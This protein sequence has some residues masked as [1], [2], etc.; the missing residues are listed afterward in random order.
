MNLIIDI[1]N[2]YSKLA[3]FQEERIL[4]K[5]QVTGS[6]I[7]SAIFEVL[8]K[9]KEIDSVIVSNV[10]GNDVRFIE[11]LPEQLNI[12]E[13]NSQ[14]KLP[15][16][17]LYVTPTT[18]GND[19]KALMAAAARQFYTQHVLVIDAGTCITY[20][21]KNNLNEYLGGAISPGLEMRYRALNHFTGRLPLE[22]KA[23]EVDLIGNTT[24][25]S[26]NSGVQN[27]ILNEV[28]GFIDAYEAK[29]ENLVVIITGGDAQF[30]SIN[31]K[32]TIFANSNFLLEGLNYILEF[33]NSQ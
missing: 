8:S 18:L 25:K 5:E 27:G 17:N 28:D 16:K 2:S 15:F 7:E 23:T 11:R 32:N 6:G 19:R 14:T 24:S 30:L 9:Y 31:L 4:E 1:G 33:N 10:S 12:V 13:L 3:V 29:Y 26:I 22:E 21:F 20:D